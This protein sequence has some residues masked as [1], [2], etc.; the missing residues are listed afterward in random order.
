MRPLVLLLTLACAAAA[1]A[2]EP[3]AKQPPPPEKRLILRPWMLPPYAVLGLPRDVLD[4][5]SKALSSIPLFNRVF[6]APLM[7]LNG[8]TT[9]LTWS[10][11]E[12]ATEGGY[13]AWVACLNLPRAKRAAPPRKIPIHMRVFPNWRT[14]GIIYW[15]PRPTPPPKPPEPPP[16]TPPPAPKAP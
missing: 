13:A 5:P 6:F 1:L 14:F 16:S 15:K 11:T 9:T 2:A 10:F 12:E 3:P 4:V 8:L 7:I